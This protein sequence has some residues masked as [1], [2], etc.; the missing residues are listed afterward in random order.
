MLWSRKQVAPFR[1]GLYWS[2]GFVESV[3]ISE[4]ISVNFVG[5]EKS[6]LLVSSKSPDCVVLG[7]MSP[8]L[9]LRESSEVTVVDTISPPDV[10]SSESV[11]VVVLTSPLE[12]MPK[13][14]DVDECVMTSPLAVWLMPPEAVMSTVS[15]VTVMDSVLRSPLAVSLTSTS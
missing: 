2:Q 1:Q 13:S 12:I 10:S 4:K 11:V 7:L 3:D 15:A 14:P 6:P 8:L 9:G 5:A